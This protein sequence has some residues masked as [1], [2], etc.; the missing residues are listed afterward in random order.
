MNIFLFVQQRGSYPVNWSLCCFMWGYSACFVGGKGWPVQSW[1]NA[2]HWP[3]PETS[4]R[5]HQ[6][7]LISEVCSC[8]THI[9]C[10]SR[11]LKCYRKAAQ[12]QPD[13]VEAL[14]CSGD[15]LF[16]SG[17]EVHIYVQTATWRI[18]LHWVFSRRRHLVC[19]VKSLK[20]FQWQGI[21]VCTL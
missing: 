7:I 13:H 12:L 6:V 3:L 2:L 19:I 9:C 18:L 10:V 4:C 15:L 11:A 8:S 17:M 1:H 14:S 16:N 5:R 20:E 21:L